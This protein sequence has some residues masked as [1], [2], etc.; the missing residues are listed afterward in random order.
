MALLLFYTSPRFNLCGW[1]ATIDTCWIKYKT[2][3]N[4]N[5]LPMRVSPNNNYLPV[6]LAKQQPSASVSIANNN[7][8]T[9]SQIMI[10]CYYYCLYF[11]DY[12]FSKNHISPT[13]T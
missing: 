13:A 4:N 8:P 1:P 5:Y 7:R 3:L 11:H 10:I 9:K 2:S 6:C 12:A